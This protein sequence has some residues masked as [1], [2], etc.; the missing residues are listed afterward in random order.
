M[1]RHRLEPHC[2]CRRLCGCACFSCPRVRSQLPPAFA[3]THARQNRATGQSTKIHRP[4]PRTR[5]RDLLASLDPAAFERAAPINDLPEILDDDV[6]A[7]IA[8]LAD[9]L[10]QTNL[11]PS[12]SRSGS[13]ASKSEGELISDVDGETIRMFA[14]GGLQIVDEYLAEPRVDDTDYT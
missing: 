2:F 13:L 9:A 1:R 11:R 3:D 5:S 7:N 14:P 6:P 8:Y 10:N 12:H 4:P